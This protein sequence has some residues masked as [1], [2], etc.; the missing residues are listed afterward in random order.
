[1][2]TFAVL[3]VVAAVAGG[4]RVAVAQ[5]GAKPPTPTK[6]HEWLKQLAGEW[7]TVG[8]MVMGPGQPPVRCKGT[9]TTRVLGGFWVVGEHKG[10]FMGTPVTGLMTVGYDPEK[11]KY[12]GT[13]VCS[14]CDR[15]F[16]YEGTVTGNV[17]TLET[18]GPDPA[19]GKLVRLRDVLEVKDKDHRVLTSLALGEDGKWVPFMTM[20]ATRKK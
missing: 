18:E 16:R 20:T 8:E 10:E 17:L 12:V 4:G 9:E 5:D 19:T 6:E 3:A 11:K 7:D 15:L 2:R 13:W 14:M 1:M